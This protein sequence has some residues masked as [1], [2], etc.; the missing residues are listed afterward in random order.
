MTN[1]S[2][3]GPSFVIMVYSL[4]IPP[5][6]M[7]LSIPNRPQAAVSHYGFVISHSPAAHASPLSKPPSTGGPALGLR[8][9][10]LFINHSAAAAYA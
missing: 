3:F 1:S 7:P 8:H 6:P 9:Y 2:D 5:P 4:V 10:G